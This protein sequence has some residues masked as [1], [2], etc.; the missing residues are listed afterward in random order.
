MIGNQ[1]DIDILNNCTS[2]T[3]K[4]DVDVT[5]QLP[6]DLSISIW[7][8]L[9]LVL[10]IV[11]HLMDVFIDLNVTFHYFQNDQ[12]LYLILTIVFI[13]VPSMINIYMSSKM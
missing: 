4:S 9:A 8:L 6:Q 3:S 2:D 12:I 1:D 10:A 7:D 5:D 13:A 11:S